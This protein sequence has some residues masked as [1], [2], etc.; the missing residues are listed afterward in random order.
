M[1]ILCDIC[2]DDCLATSSAHIS[3]KVTFR[4][5]PEKCYSVLHFAFEFFKLFVTSTKTLIAK[6]CTFGFFASCAEKKTAVEDGWD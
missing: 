3:S 1:A 5:K 6:L 4:S 2:R